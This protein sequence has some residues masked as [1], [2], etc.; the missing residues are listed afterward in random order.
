MNQVILEQRIHELD[1]MLATWEPRSQHEHEACYH[2]RE[3]RQSLVEE[4][5]D[6]HAIYAV[7]KDYKMFI[8]RSQ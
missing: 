7:C 6:R 5:E 4:I 1:A 8:N 2:L 3:A